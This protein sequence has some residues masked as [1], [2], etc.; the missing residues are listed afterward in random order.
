MIATQ[1]TRSHAIG[2][3]LHISVNTVDAKMK[4]K[5]GLDNGAE[6]TG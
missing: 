2:E 6:L 1:G 5:P 4:R 3:P